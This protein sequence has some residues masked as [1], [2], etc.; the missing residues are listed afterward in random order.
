MRIGGVRYPPKRRS[1]IPAHPQ[2]PPG[3]AGR[4]NRIGTV[5]ITP[6]DAAAAEEPT[7]ADESLSD[8]HA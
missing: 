5:V 8:S 4:R 2:P 1:V 7:D 6:L 3:P